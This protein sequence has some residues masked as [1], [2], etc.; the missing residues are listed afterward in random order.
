MATGAANFV[1]ARL[2]IEMQAEI[3]GYLDEKADMINIRLALPGAR[4][5]T[6]PRLFDRIYLSLST[7][8]LENA[9]NIIENFGKHVL[10]IETCPLTYEPCGQSLVP[11]YNILK[12]R[13]TRPPTR[14]QE[15]YQLSY[16]N[17]HKF[18][19]LTA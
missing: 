9:K 5:W 17:Y 13:I 19:K 18:E 2:P 12:R 15:H 16:V 7:K 8:S 14:Q 6:T 3:V 10:T 11:I 1:M 4:I